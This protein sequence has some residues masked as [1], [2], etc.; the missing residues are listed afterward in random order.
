MSAPDLSRYEVDIAGLPQPLLEHHIPL[1][2]Q[3]YPH[4]RYVTAVCV[5]PPGSSLN[6]Y[7]M[8]TE[9]ELAMIVSFHEEYVEHYYGLP[10]YGYLKQQRDK[11][12]FDIDGGANGRFLM[13]VGEDSWRMRHQSW[14]DAVPE[15]GDPTRTLIELMDNDY[16][17]SVRWPS[18][19]ADRPEI[20]GGA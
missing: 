7:L 15:Y 1:I 20:F 18:W 8:P 13:K 4:W 17:L 19:K 9:R 2:H 10:V 5:S 16:S 6:K 11:H 14:S 3:E 12:P